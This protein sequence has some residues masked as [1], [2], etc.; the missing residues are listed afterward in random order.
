MQKFNTQNIE[1]KNQKLVTIRQATVEDAEKLLNCIK[2]YLPESEYIPRLQEEIK[3]TLEQEQERI[4]TF[5]TSENSLLL[6]A[7]YENEIIG[8]I[9]LN[10]SPMKAMEHTAIIGMGLLKEW[11]GSGLGSVLMKSVVDWA[12][13]NPMLELIWLQVYTENSAGLNLYRKM[14]FE[15]N[16]LVKNFFKQHGKYYDNL[17]MSMSVK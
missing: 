17:T 5:R 1:L 13:A 12:K 15:E 6:V 7:E 16:G 14:G 9:D 2:K 10:G 4:N 3:L 8:N 11:R